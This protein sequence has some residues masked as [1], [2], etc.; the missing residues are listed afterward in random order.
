MEKKRL[1]YAA[2]PL[3]CSLSLGLSQR[4]AHAV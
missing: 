4:P 2:V 3:N 1:K